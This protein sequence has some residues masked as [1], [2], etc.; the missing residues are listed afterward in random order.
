M[1]TYARAAVAVAA[2]AVATIVVVAQER[3]DLT[4][5]H[6]IKQEAFQ[7]SKV[8]EHLFYLT[9][10]HGPRLTSSPGYVAAADWAMKA[11]SAWGLENVKREKWGPFGRSWSLTR[12]S[13]H[14]L[15]PQYTPLIAVPLAWSPS[16]EGVITGEPILAPMPSLST[17]GGGGE[18]GRPPAFDPAQRPAPPSEAEVDRALERFKGKLKGKIVLTAQPRPLRPHAAPDSQ[19]FSDEQLAQTALAPDPQ[20]A[21]PPFQFD[22]AQ[23]QRRRN[24]INQ[25]L[26]D[27]G[28]V[29]AITTGFTGD[30]GTIF[31]T[32]AGSRDPKD[33]LPPPT[34][35][36][37]PEH[38]NRIT[39]LLEKKIPVKLEVELQ[40]QLHDAA[41]SFNITAE[42][43]GGKKRDEIVMLGAH[44]DSWHAGTGAT[45]NAAG[46]AVALEALR[47][48]KNLDLKMDRTVRL[49]LWGGEEQGL[50]GSRAYVK[51]R[52]A[53]PEVMKPT[54]EHGKLAAYFNL[55]NGTGKVRGVY[56]Q[57]N[58]M[59]RPIFETW[60]APFRDLGATTLSI[61]NTGGTDHLSFDAVGLP[62]F[63][64]IQDRV[65]YDTRTH[66]SNMDVYDRIQAADM[67]QASAIMASFVYQAA[68]RPEMLPRKPLPK[69]QP[70]RR[71]PGERPA[72]TGA[73]N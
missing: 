19:R 45:D 16:T 7:S 48:L 49:A 13:A 32:S 30:G 63:Q 47:I 41:E 20:Q 31:A 55:D 43:P 67:M 39:R 28:V 70:K 8:M 61:R 50:L 64:F 65:E 60:L 21:R 34:I 9:D 66:H 6:R 37:T 33:V 2:A 23:G 11:L 71:G 38:Y 56:L 53:D 17:R 24:R 51:E 5:I 54:T 44:F 10:V 69:P 15:E 25:F 36:L 58:D 72:G 12:L 68:M 1:Q 18:P 3:T 42:L 40:T 46:S 14:L 22:Q 57:N 27:E 62:G 52:F 59:V 35:A 4:T 73:V 26:K 29:L